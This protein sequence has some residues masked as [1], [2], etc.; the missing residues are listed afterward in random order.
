M[1]PKLLLLDEPAQW[2]PTKVDAMFAA[3]RTSLGKQPDSLLLAL[4]T[5]GGGAWPSVRSA[6]GVVRLQER[7]CVLADGRFP[8]L[9]DV[10][11]CQSELTYHAGFGGGHKSGEHG[12]AEGRK[13][14][15]FVSRS[16]IEPG[17]R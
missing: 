1:A 14:A 13:P 16:A 10:A 12:C 15:S 4:G 3:L 6:V 7:L 8:P 9:Q 2:M 11:F 17:R 5:R